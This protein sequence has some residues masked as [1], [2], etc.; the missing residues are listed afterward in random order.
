MTVGDLL[1]VRFWPQAGWNLCVVE[2]LAGQRHYAIDD[3]RGNRRGAPSSPPPTPSIRRG[4]S[5]F[6][7]LFSAHRPVGQHDAGGAVRGQIW[8]MLSQA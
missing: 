3:A 7:G 2:Q 4:G 5:P 1:F 8:V 6:A